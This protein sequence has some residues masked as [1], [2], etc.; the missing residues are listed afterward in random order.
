MAEVSGGFKPLKTKEDYRLALHALV[1]AG[2][3]VLVLLG[4]GTGQSWVTWTAVGFAA[5]DP[6]FSFSNTYDGLRK[7]I[8]GLGGLAQVVLLG[9]G[10]WSESDVALK[11]GALVTFLTAVI[12][13]FYT[14]NSAVVNPVP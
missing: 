11:V 4:L 1:A 12:A 13:I 7:V 9:V 5:I 3:P 8:Y 14:P 6:L 10:Q 2:V